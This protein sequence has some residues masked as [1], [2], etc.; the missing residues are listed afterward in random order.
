MMIEAIARRRLRRRQ[1]VGLLVGGI[2][3]AVAGTGCG[4]PLPALPPATIPPFPGHRSAPLLVDASALHDALRNPVR[5]VL[6]LDLSA[7]RR[8]R[9]AHIP[10]AVHAWWRDTTERNYPV[11]GTVLTHQ[12]HQRY[13][14]RLLKDL[15]IAD[16][17]MVIAYD[18][19]RG[20]WA[21]RM[22]WFLRFLGHDRAA[23]LDGGLAAWRGAGGRTERGVV[24]PPRVPT[25]TVKPRAGYYL[26]TDELLER[27]DDPRTLLVDVR[28]PA[29]ARDDV[30]GLLPLGRIPGSTVLPWT[31]ALRDEIGRLKSPEELSRLLEGKG[32]TRD[33]QVVLY[34]RFGVEAAHTWLVLQLMAYPE[35]VVYDRGWAEWA[36]TPGLPVMP[37]EADGAAS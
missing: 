36:T 11:F 2:A 25:P 30:N 21:A 24:T 37:L 1:V 33:R 31:E 6:V 28:T 7:P 23:A 32:I 15:G 20:R 3:A 17:T 26:A 8:Y 13:R 19:D 14:I 16:E 27:L 9:R 22:V 5:P 34:A 4:G 18:D 35:V 29:E 12:E 10:G